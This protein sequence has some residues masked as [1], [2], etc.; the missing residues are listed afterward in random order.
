M[1]KRPDIEEIKQ[2]QEEQLNK[3]KK[4][5]HKET[6]KLFERNVAKDFGT[7]RTPLSGMV[8]TITN[9]DTLHRK[10]YIECKLR[11]GV[12]G[13]PFWKNFEKLRTGT[14][15]ECM[16]LIDKDGRLLWLV[17]RDDFFKLMEPAKFQSNLIKTVLSSKI[18]KSLLSLYSETTERAEIEGKIPVVAIKKKNEKSYLIGT[19]PN[20][21]EVLHNILKRGKNVRKI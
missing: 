14:S 17:T 11:G 9:S 19:H 4:T 12:S 15:I 7:T 21:F 3:K 2:F 10:I 6:W 8:K 20:N 13:F 5:T 18:Y 16:E 1:P